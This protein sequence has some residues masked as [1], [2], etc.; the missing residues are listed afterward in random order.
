MFTQNSNEL[1]VLFCIPHIILSSNRAQHSA[2][3][4][5][6]YIL[7]CTLIHQKMT[8][9]MNYFCDCVLFR[10]NSGQDAVFSWN[11]CSP[12]FSPGSPQLGS[13]WPHTCL[14]RNIFFFFLFFFPF[15]FFSTFFLSYFSL[16][17]KCK[18]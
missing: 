15:P 6:R 12:L 7:V 17:V 9:E 1:L 2:P 5:F 8:R 14:L 10:E 11:E 16:S 4:V 3:G 18:S 13:A